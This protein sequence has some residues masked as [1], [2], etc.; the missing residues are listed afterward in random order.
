MALAKVI[1]N[2]AWLGLIQVLSYI[3]PLLTLPVVTRAFGPGIF[4]V[5]ATFM[6]YAGYVGLVMNFGYNYTGPRSVSRLHNMPGE[7]SRSVS[8]VI[9]SQVVLGAAAT[10]TLI[11]VMSGF[12]LFGNYHWAAGI[13]ASQVIVNSLV[14]QWVFVGLERV[15]DFALLQFAIRLL[16][17]I[18]IVIFIRNPSDLLLYLGINFVSSTL[19]LIGSVIILLWYGIFWRMPSVG[20]VMAPIRDSTRLFFSTIAMNLYTSTNVVLVSLLLGAASAGEFALADRLRGAAG[21]LT[22]P[23]TSAI[24]PFICRISGQEA[25]QEDVEV[26]RTFFCIIALFSALVSGF[27]LIF[28]SGIVHAIGGHAF[29]GAIPVLRIMSFL[30]MTIAI[31]NILGIQ[32]MLPL[33]MDRELNVIVTTAACLGIVGLL[34]S[35]Y[36]YGV[37][38]AAFAALLV[39]IFVTVSMAVVVQ[40]R[41]DVFSL[42]FKPRNT[43]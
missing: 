43:Q 21:S 9:S 27:L 35:A 23:I 7:L 22:A 25:R 32:T 8:A 1:Q 2:A 5:V 39:E 3:L 20:D 36:L 14:P 4:G 38:G 15:R 40:R 30:P 29:E 33:G 37:V 17:A 12:G 19:I 18:C 41:V 11:G 31:S 26:K 6:A 42:F 16:A 34:G 28:S 10:I 24:Y 13:I